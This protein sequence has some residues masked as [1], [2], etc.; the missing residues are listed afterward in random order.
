MFRNDE[1]VLHLRFLVFQVIGL[2]QNN[3]EFLNFI[4][5][6]ELPTDLIDEPVVPE[7]EAPIEDLPVSG[8]AKPSAKHTRL[9]AVRAR[10]QIRA[11]IEPLYKLA[12]SKEFDDSK[13][14]AFTTG[15]A[16]GHGE[17]EENLAE[18][19]K[20]F[21]FA[22]SIVSP[23]FSPEHRVEITRALAELV[24]DGVFDG[25]TLKALAVKIVDGGESGT[26]DK[27]CEYSENLPIIKV[28]DELFEEIDGQPQDITHIL[29]HE[30]SHGLSRLA[31]IGSDEETQNKIGA[32]I[33]DNNLHFRESYRTVNALNQFAAAKN[34]EGVTDE[35]IKR[36]SA[37]LSEEILAEKIVA[38][39]ASGGE[40]SGFICE[41]GDTMPPE[42]QRRLR[43]DHILFKTWLDENRFFFE[44]I[45][46]QMA[47]K[48]KLKIKIA[49]ASQREIAEADLD[50]IAGMFDFSGNY[51]GGGLSE[52]AV[53]K[54]APA[55][56][57]DNIWNALANFAGT[58]GDEIKSVMPLPNVEQ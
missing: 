13:I 7:T 38:Y 19:L 34:R 27:V 4:I 24:A 44:K 37:W 15:W 2:T 57:G 12:Q 52:P 23:K 1:F 6:T 21:Q 56:S 48:E 11:G 5:M 25:E 49:E 33:A 3:E 9:K 31:G 45:Q 29:K 54:N 18:T 22:E 55:H 14:I 58:F 20:Y 16:K 41:L 30:I 36:W 26:M 17:S 28:Y 47:D 51:F 42:N 53:P 39:L 8:D 50:D 10:Q 35:E 43:A 46:S 32:L 40:F